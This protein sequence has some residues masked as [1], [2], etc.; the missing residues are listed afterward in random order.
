MARSVR[1]VMGG[2]SPH[3][4][5]RAGRLRGARHGFALRAMLLRDGIPV[6]G[7]R[8]PPANHAIFVKITMT[9]TVMQN[10]GDAEASEG[11]VLFLC[12]I[13]CLGLQ[14]HSIYIMYK[15]SMN[16]WGKL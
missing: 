5:R 7:Q 3:A 14:K 16:G 11:A 15:E 12:K 1:Y 9:S 4:A 6:S 8:Q 13:S 2:I 10:C